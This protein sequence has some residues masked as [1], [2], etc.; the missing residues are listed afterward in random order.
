MVFLMLK[1]SDY[2]WYDFAEFSTLEEML[3]AMEKD[4]HPFVLDKNQLRADPNRVKEWLNI[5]SDYV[6]N[7]VAQCEY[8]ITIYDDYLE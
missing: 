2:E 3:I 6:A 5:E 4:G 7:Q 1:A 8:E